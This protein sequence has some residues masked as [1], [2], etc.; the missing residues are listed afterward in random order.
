M[1]GLTLLMIRASNVTEFLVRVRVRV[2]VGIRIR[3]SGLCTSFSDDRVGIKGQSAGGG[4]GGQKGRAGEIF[5]LG[6][7]DFLVHIGH[8]EQK[9]GVLLPLLLILPEQLLVAGLRVGLVL[10]Q[11]RDLLAE[12]GDGLLR[13]GRVDDALHVL[14]ELLEAP[15]ELF[16]PPL[17]PLRL[18]GREG[19]RRCR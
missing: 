12:M 5:G 18:L 7:A 14:G 1:R 3:Q 15:V 8:L 11:H 4:G 2:R 19:R 10:L 16:F 9:R 13:V 6:T 17:L